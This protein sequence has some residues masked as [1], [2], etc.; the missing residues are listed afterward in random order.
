MRTALA[1]HLASRATLGTYSGAESPARFGDV[2]AEFAA[3]TKSAG[4]YDLGWRA[5]IKVTGDDRIRWM[6]GMVTNNIRDLQ[7]NQGNYNFVLSPQGRIQG[8]MYIYHRGDHLI[9]DTEFSQRDSLMKL[10]DHFIIMDDVELQDISSEVTSLGLQG[11]R[12]T[13]ILRAVGIEPSCADP[14]VVC[15]VQWQGGTIQVTRMAWDNLLTYELLMPPELTL[16]TWDAVVAAGPHPVGFEVWKSSVSS[17]AFPN[18]EL[19]SG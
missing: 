16:H 7:P 5:K 19:I 3:L 11:P 8:D 10:F 14:L 4:V 18:T 13:E 2:A 6:N 15:D 1:E 17:Q 12:A 9:V